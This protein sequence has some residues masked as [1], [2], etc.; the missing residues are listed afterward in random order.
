MDSNFL[1]I[2]VLVI[3]CASDCIYDKKKLDPQ[4]C[5]TNSFYERTKNEKLKLPHTWRRFFATQ[6]EIWLQSEINAND[7]EKL[8]LP[9]K[10]WIILKFRR[11]N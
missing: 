11:L 3:T 10:N 1:F 6:T 9:Q 8:E 5:T 4:Y 7:V 2:F